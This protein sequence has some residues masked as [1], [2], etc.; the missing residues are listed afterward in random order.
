MI[1][2]GECLARFFIANSRFLEENGSFLLGVGHGVNTPCRWGVT[3]I[4]KDTLYD[5]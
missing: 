2:Q 3:Y 1:E 4:T 5:E